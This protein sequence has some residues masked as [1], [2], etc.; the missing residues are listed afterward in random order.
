MKVSG[1]TFVRDAAKYDYPVVESIRSILP[2]ADK[3]IVN[4][5]QRNDGTLELIRSIG[6]PI[7]V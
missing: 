2:V 3:F 6:G 4:I 5:G 1:F 7:S